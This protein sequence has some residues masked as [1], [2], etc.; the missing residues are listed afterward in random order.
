MLILIQSHTLRADGAQSQQGH[1]P[2]QIPGEGS[3]LRCLNYPPPLTV[4]VQEWPVGSSSSTGTQSE[5]WSPEPHLLSVSMTGGRR[6]T[7]SAQLPI[8]QGA[9]HRI[10]P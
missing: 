5:D 7:S 1:S 10:L 9:P 2:S 3:I 6:A 4:S 8:V